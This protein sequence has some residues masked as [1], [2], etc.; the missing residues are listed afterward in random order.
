MELCKDCKHYNDV[1]DLCVRGKH[2]V[3]VDLIDGPPVYEYRV[4]EPAHWQR[5]SIMPWKCGKRGR[6]FEPREAK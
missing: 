3:G 2:Q 4:L 1:G 6:Y 5:G